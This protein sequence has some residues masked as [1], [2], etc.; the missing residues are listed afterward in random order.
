MKKHWRA[1]TGLLVCF[2]IL[3]AGTIGY[4]L[5]NDFLVKEKNHSN[6]VASI[7][8]SANAGDFVILEI[9]PD[10][11]YA[12]LGYL[13]AGSE[14]IDILK[15]SKAGKADEIAKIAGGGVT[16]KKTIDGETYK[17]LNQI[18]DNMDKYWEQ[19]ASG[20]SIQANN[21]Y[22]FVGGKSFP[23]NTNSL[24]SMFSSQ[25]SS[26]DK[27]VVKT[28]T[29]KDLNAAETSDIKALLDKTDLI[30]VS[31]SYVDG[32]KS[33]QQ[34]LAKNYAGESNP[35]QKF[36]SGKCDASWSVVKTIF[37]YV[38]DKENPLPIMM[39]KEIYTDA[40]STDSES[41][42][43]V[44][45][46]LNRNVKYA[47]KT[48]DTWEANGDLFKKTTYKAGT[49]KAASNN[50]M[51]KLYLMSMFRDPAEFYNL[52]VE[53]KLIDGSGKYALQ[54]GNAASYWN[55]YTF[56]PCK[57]EIKHSDHE[58]GDTSFWENDMSISL[59]PKSG[60]WV[61]C[62][63][64]SF[65][66]NKSSSFLDSKNEIV[67][68]L[69]YKP[70]SC[71]NGETYDVLELEPA[72]HFSLSAAY[73][74]QLL[75]YTSYTTKDTFKLK[76][77]KMTTAEYV[78]KTSELASNYDLVYIGNDIKGLHT[79]KD[80]NGKLITD[81]SSKNEHMN[82]V[83][84]AHLGAKVLF[85]YGQ[86]TDTSN[87][88]GSNSN[89]VAFFNAGDSGTLHYSGNDITELKKKQLTTYLDT[90]L[91]V[92][93][94]DGLIKDA[95][96]DSPMYFNDKSNNN[97]RNFLKERADDLLSLDFNYRS[98]S[99]EEANEKINRLTKKKPTLTISSLR[100]GGT[101][102]TDL[103][104][105]NVYKF[106][107]NSEN[108]KFTFS[109]KV[110]NPE[111]STADFVLNFY[112]D[113]NAD[114]RFTKAE[115]IGGKSFTGN[116]SNYTYTFSMN[117]SYT[118]AFTW[119]IE[120]YP[121]NNPGM[122][123]SQIGYSTIRFTNNDVAKRTVHVL[124]VQ[125]VGGNNKH[126]TDW[127]R[128]KAQQ[129]N[130]S[131]SAFTKYLKQDEVSKD[132]DIKITVIDLQD[133]TY[134]KDGSEY[135][136]KDHGGW[137]DKN[138]KEK[139]SR[140]NLQEKYDMI[141]FG[142]ADSY[143]DLEFNNTKI[144]KD[145]QDYIDAGKSVMFSHDLT[146]QINNENALKDEKNTSVFMENTNGKGFNKW[147]RDAMG[148]DRYNQGKRISSKKSCNNYTK[149][150][151]GEKYGFTYTALMQYSNFRRNW[152]KGG[153][154]HIDG[155]FGPYNPLYINLLSRNNQESGKDAGKGW[156]YIGIPDGASTPED[157]DA[158]ATQRVTEVN[159]GQIT[160][161]PFDL[162]EYK[163]SDGTYPISTTHGQAYQLNVESDDVVCWFAL[164]DKGNGKGWYSASPNDA[165]NNYYIYNKGNVTYTGVGHSKL[166]EMTEF[167]K[168]LFINTMIA[169]LRA[170]VEGP[171]P[172]ITNGFNIPEG[173]EDCYVVYADVDA[174][175]EDKEFN[176]TED[177]EF[178]AHDDST[179]A[180]FV[181]VSL[182]V[183]GKKGEEYEEVS[184]G[185]TLVDQNGN[186]LSP[187]TI[188]SEEDGETHKAWKIK[189]SD[190]ASDS[191]VITY[192]I[193]YPR[194]V[195]EHQASQKFKIYAYS[196]EGE[197]KYKVKGYQYG[198][199]MRRAQFKL[200]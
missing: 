34:D 151:D 112:V 87:S 145:I 174:D 80:S 17:Q 14:P 2:A 177:V 146:S 139:L 65:E 165:A 75:P 126:N 48:K 76:I 191:G 110:D 195:L 88:N 93:V 43:T 160:K 193:K 86:L 28:V 25:I 18:Y 6:V 13:Q 144:A 186:T 10:M 101:T 98:V 124:Q 89:G 50:N 122:V 131:D 197:G 27:V 73:I 36:T 20:S 42:D 31:E 180:E 23:I 141:I 22:T 109:Y 181:Y 104:K 95:K 133:F 130:L 158:Y 198:G 52:F 166:S 148:L 45:Y 161:Y 91:P 70:R 60:K 74:E 58:E 107:K 83:I 194:A 61:N 33:A 103:S 179:K 171:Q 192:T 40:L 11:S 143:R 3:A 128:G 29:A 96:K 81:Y 5:N 134:G 53:S 185:Y 39:D 47:S 137:Y 21:K 30:Y 19:T 32:A 105:C 99:D 78:G 149:T 132:F 46:E 116:G 62:N 140:V 84:Y 168:K 175:S 54:S 118:G 169:A 71:I 119:K 106:D 147:M 59:E 7:A 55:T 4:F 24:R 155:W 189:K 173:D 102:Y 163:N 138:Y 69:K 85:N 49:S 94:A 68:I 172:E 66:Q 72:N 90:G 154:N 178:Y 187:V 9:V 38:A 63:G 196:Y 121:K 117:P 188:T 182:A 77:T 41:V 156:P 115:R 153:K 162:S 157:G 184:D 200:D 97:M 44:Q 142:F 190:L 12:Q 129:I 8:T 167:E 26:D 114:G 108:R 183:Q 164:S 79:K 64:I 135:Y 35:G 136:N 125:A 100:A 127:G 170:G 82:G 92:V 152:N 1:F 56:L 120:V 111:D 159:E 113:K 16:L 176:K 51:Y 37:Q 15:A 57:K 150:S 67:Q 123:C 199:I